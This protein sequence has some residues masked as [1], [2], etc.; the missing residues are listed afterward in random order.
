MKLSKLDIIRQLK[1][2]ILSLTLKPGDMISEA[3]LT[4]RFGLSRTPIRDILKVLQSEGYVTIFP[5]RG[6]VVSSIDLDSVEQ[7]VYM[8]N[9][10]EKEIFRDLKS[11]LTLTQSHE[12]L[13][14]IKEQEACIQDL[15]KFLV[16][17]DQFHFMCYDFAGRS[18]LWQVME[19]LN[20]HYLR[21]RY[22]NMT[23]T[24]KLKALAEEHKKLFDYLKGNGD[25]TIEEL[26]HHHLRIDEINEAFTK[27]YKEYLKS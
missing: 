12:L 7:I 14:I 1:E 21:Y 5:Q 22:L 8:R 10:I 20:V 26:I 23:N 3:T 25:Q 2:E 4:Q 9:A 17:D 27:D 13:E 24:T 19:Q 11:T 16:L 18:F 15:D 6:S